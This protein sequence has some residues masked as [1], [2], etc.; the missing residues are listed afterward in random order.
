MKFIS[1]GETLYFKALKTKDDNVQWRRIGLDQNT[2]RI[3]GLE[4]ASHLQTWVV[5]RHDPIYMC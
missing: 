3:V 1:Y 5:M 4:H 2:T